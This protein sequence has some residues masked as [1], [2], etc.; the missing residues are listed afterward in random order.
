MFQASGT[1]PRHGSKDYILISDKEI[2]YE[3]GLF[4]QCISSGSQTEEIKG[5]YCS[6]FIK[7]QP[8]QKPY[9]LEDFNINGKSETG[10]ELKT[11]RM[12]VAKRQK[13]YH[14]PVN[15]ADVVV[16]LCLPSSCSAQDVRNAVAQMI[17]R[18]T[19]HLVRKT[20]ESDDA[21][22]QKLLYSLLSSTHDDFCYTKSKILEAGSHDGL[23]IAF[24]YI[25]I[26]SLNIYKLTSSISF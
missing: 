14:T 20:H 23:S 18:N 15:Q 12:S 19:F 25:E 21:N 8:L 1:L 4:D 6:I 9:S 10:L 2:R 24:M 3:L 11:P 22:N 13:N 17:G 5:Q 26:H 16:G 7:A